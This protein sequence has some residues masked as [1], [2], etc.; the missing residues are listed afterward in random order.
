MLTFK[1]DSNGDLVDT[2]LS[3]DTK[4]TATNGEEIVFASSPLTKLDAVPNGAAII[5]M[6][7]GTVYLYDADGDEWKAW[8]V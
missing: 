1:F 4:P 6:D 5:E 3:S 8:G 2:G 7:T